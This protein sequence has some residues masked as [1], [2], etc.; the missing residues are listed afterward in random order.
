MTLEALLGSTLLVSEKAGGGTVQA[1]S[2]KEK[3]A[4]LLYFSAHWCPPCRAFTPVLA[5]GYR[6]TWKEKGIEFVFVSS[7]KSEAEFKEYFAT[8]PWLAVYYHS[9]CDVDC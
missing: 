4:V 5:E 3:K 1:S 2:L 6:R 7:D 9:H 8:M